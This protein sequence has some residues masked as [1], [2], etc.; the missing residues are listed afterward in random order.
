MKI[1]CVIMASGLATRFGSNKLLADFF[2]KPVLQRVL[3]NLPLQSLENAVVVTRY[4]EIACLCEELGMPYVLH[5]EPLQRDTIRIGMQ[6][7]RHMDGC[8][9]CVGDQPLCTR[10]SISLLLTE[11]K[12]HPD[13]IVRLCYG[14][15]EGNPVLFPPALYE[16]L[17]QLP[18]SAGG[19]YIIKKYPELLRCVQSTN[20]WEICDIDT[21]ED[22]QILKKACSILL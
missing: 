9:F 2:G 10:K 8:L 3:E 14:A 18:D 13:H 17:T 16:E 1:G 19:N 20:Q 7:M 5:N 21:I 22:L 12:R 15:R 4:E 11:F 6:L